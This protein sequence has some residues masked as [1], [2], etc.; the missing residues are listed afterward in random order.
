MARNFGRT[1]ALTLTGSNQQVV[2]GGGPTDLRVRFNIISH[3][4]QAPNLAEIIVTNP[5]SE[6]VALVQQ[7]FSKLSLSAGYEDNS[8]IIFSGS[9]TQTQYGQKESGFTD[10]LLRIWASDSDLG[11]N[12]AVV[13]TTLAAGA[14]PQDVVNICLQALA[15]YGITMGQVTGVDLSTPKFPRPYVLAGMARDY[16][17]EV[18]TSKQ[19]TFH[20][21]NS[22]LNI[23]GKDAAKSDPPI[24]LSADTGMI[25]QPI[26]T[27]AGIIVQCLIN[28]AIQVGGNVKIDP[29]SIV[30]TQFSNTTLQTSDLDQQKLLAKQGV[31]SGTYKVLHIETE[32]DTR[33]QPWYHILTCIGT[34][35]SLNSIQAGLG[36]S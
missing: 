9:V 12:N 17:R 27:V 10:T 32:G 23:I 30:K 22:Q 26:Q 11:Y 1:C 3:T 24:V 31:T 19:A 13:N 4:L 28:S 6:T 7:E 21:Y 34:G 29:S 18:A 14:T 33:G 8:G 36:Y 16:L 35:G 25:G 15:K 2:K 20:I 5:S